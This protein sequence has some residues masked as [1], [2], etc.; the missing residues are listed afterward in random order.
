MKVCS[1]CGQ[2]KSLDAFYRQQGGAYGRRGMCKVCFRAAD[3]A[4]WA[5]D[6]K[7]QTCRRE[8]IEWWRDEG[9]ASDQRSGLRGFRNVVEATTSGTADDNVPDFALSHSFD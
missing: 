1:S 6:P 9:W 8:I 7:V 3:R 2:R 4:S 5:N